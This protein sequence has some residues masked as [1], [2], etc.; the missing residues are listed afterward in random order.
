MKADAWFS[1]LLQQSPI[2]FS[3]YLPAEHFNGYM[4]FVR[5]AELMAYGRALSEEDIDEI[6][7]L[8]RT[9]LTYYE[10]K[11]YRRRWKRISV[12]LPVIHQLSHVA[13][14]I[15]RLG[16]MG[17]YTQ[18]PIERQAYLGPCAFDV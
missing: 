10:E 9:F 1:W 4:S 14:T 17:N 2:Y 16:P 12:C 8:I 15:R 5:A 11:L 13:E 7:G 6:D 3:K 18:F